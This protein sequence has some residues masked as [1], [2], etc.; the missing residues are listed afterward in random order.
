MARPVADYKAPNYWLGYRSGF[1][2][3][4]LPGEVLRR[5]TAG[6]PTYRQMERMG[7][8]LSRAAAVS[9]VPMA[10]DVALRAPGTLPRMVATGLLMSS[11][12]TCSLLL[13]DVGR[14][15]AIGVLALALLSTARSAWLRLPLPASAVLIAGAVSV[16]VASE[17]F[18]LAAL[19]PTVAAAVHLLSRHHDLSRN[20][21]L[22]LLGGVLAPGVAVAGASLLT[23]VPAN[24][25]STARAEALRAGVRPAG[26]IGDALAALNRGFV[27][28]L[29]YFRL[30]GRT[31]IVLSSA[32][33]AG[34]YF[35]TAR[36]LKKLLSSG[37]GSWYSSLVTAHALVGAALSAAG[38]DFRRWWGLALVGLMSAVVLTD[39]SSTGEPVATAALGGALALAVAGVLPRDLKVYPWGRVRDERALPLTG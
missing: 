12:L 8:A 39:A 20:H 33:W 9:I 34:F 5:L 7:V 21:E 3:R 26:P 19:A 14:Y 32:V 4:G 24:A 37:A 16:A 23:P 30:F 25:L 1:V 28:N 2:R 29:A 38:V 36:V 18:L 6:R 13:H 35:L 15:D 22:Q 27:E 10:V 31:P 11:P 17:E